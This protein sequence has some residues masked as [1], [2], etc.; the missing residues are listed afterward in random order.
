MRVAVTVISPPKAI[1][2]A[3]G[4]LNICA[5]Q[6]VLLS[7]TTG[8][9]YSYQWYQN[10]YGIG[11]ADSA[12]YVAL[13]SASYYVVITANGCSAQSDSVTVSVNQYPADSV[14]VSGATTFCAGGSVSL[15]AS[16][17]SGYSYQWQVNGTNIQGATTPGFVADS[18]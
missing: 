14:S 9:N 10:D 18:S 17:G 11:G 13:D 2:T 5:G 7:A 8:A 15:T 3:S 12:T 16:A 6:S 1:V 4:S